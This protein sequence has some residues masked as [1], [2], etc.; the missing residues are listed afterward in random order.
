MI[1]VVVR[2]SVPYS[3]IATQALVAIERRPMTIDTRFLKGQVRVDDLLIRPSGAQ[4]AVAV[5]LVADLA[6]PLPRVRG[7][8]DLAATP[9]FD[10]P[11]QT[12]RLRDVSVTA[13]IDHVLARA[14]FVYKRGEI[15]EALRD[16][17]LEV[18]PLLRDLRDR[19]NSSLTGHALAPGVELHGQVETM[20]VEDLLV[21]EELVI[22]AS[23][24]GRLR[25]SVAPT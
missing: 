10:G 2:A 1:S 16:L 21:A 12:L 19:L 23:A 3:E 13:D 18:E 8:L 17:S 5:T 15:V 11:S 4:L 22:V 9:A 20:R 14:A 25:V 6:W 7:T 24:S